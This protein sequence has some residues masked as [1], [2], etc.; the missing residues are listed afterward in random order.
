[1]AATDKFGSQRESSRLTRSCI[2]VAC[3]VLGILLIHFTGIVASADQTREQCDKCCKNSQQD[4]YYLEQCKLKCFRN[5]E[6]C[7]DL[8]KHREAAPAPTESE[9]PRA[10]HP[11]QPATV[12]EPVQPP[13]P[14]PQRP[15]QPKPAVRAEIVIPNPLTLVPGKEWEAAGQ[16]LM[17]NGISPQSPKYQAGLRSIEAVLIEFAKANP[18]GGKLP[19]AQL[20]RIIRQAR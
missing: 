2:A 4:E 3:V 13:A 9:V 14:H 18:A 20:E 15:E 7:S 12:A 19:K 6:H 10:A 17:A 5:P 1:V 8:K 16:I 11:R